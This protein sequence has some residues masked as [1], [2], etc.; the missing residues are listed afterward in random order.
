MKKVFSILLACI[1]LFSNI[2]F[3]ISNHYCGGSIAESALSIGKSD[4]GCGMETDGKMKCQK[5][6]HQNSYSK[7]PCC[8]DE[9][10]QFNINENYTTFTTVEEN[11]N[12][13]FIAAFVVSC[14]NLYYFNNSKILEYLAYSHPP[15][16]QNA[17]ALFQS[18]LL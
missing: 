15:P 16:K 13:T 8:A 7:T 9:Y 6:S 11:I 18:F 17:Q 10:L 12:I 2:G 1:F 4:V 3:T 5:K 14:S